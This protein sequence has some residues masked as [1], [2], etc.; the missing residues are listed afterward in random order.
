[1][2][3]CAINIPPLPVVGFIDPETK[4]ISSAWSEFFDLIVNALRTNAS[5]EGLVA[6]SQPTGN[7]GIIAANQLQ[8]GSYTTNGGAL[9]YDSTTDQLKVAILSAG[10]P[11]FKIVTVT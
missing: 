4:D 2:E 7:I 8:N 6:P 11:T 1:M 3:E 5:N 10:V 9:V